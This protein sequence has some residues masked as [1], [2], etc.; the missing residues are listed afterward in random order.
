MSPFYLETSS[1]YIQGK[2]KSLYCPKALNHKLLCQFFKYFSL[3]YIL[4]LSLTTFF[5]ISPKHALYFH[6]S[7]HMMPPLPKILFSSLTIQW[8][9]KLIKPSS[10]PAS[11]AK[12]S[13]ILL[14]K[15]NT[16][17]VCFQSTCFWNKSQYFIKWF[18][19]IYLT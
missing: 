2:P 15:L 12:S 8:N 17:S 19:C 18:L 1:P 10:N 4:H 5:T 9:P 13:L 7:E 11:S 16:I 3:L 14:G 6:A